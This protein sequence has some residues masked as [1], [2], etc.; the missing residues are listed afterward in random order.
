MVG[1]QRR[2]AGGAMADN[3]LWVQQRECRRG[4]VSYFAHDEHIQAGPGILGSP[5]QPP[6][7]QYRQIR[8]AG[9]Y[10]RSA[11]GADLVLIGTYFG[12]GVGFAAP[13]A[14]P[15]F[16]H[17]VEY[18]LASLPIPQ[19]IINMHE[20]PPRRPLHEW[21][22][23]AHGTRPSILRKVSYTV[24]PLTAYDA[25]FFVDAIKPSP[26]P[27]HTETLPGVD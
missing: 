27:T 11:L 25:I 15:Y 7:G 24:T 18:L 23:M 8:G 21:F 3:V 22:Q 5:G 2:D 13:D 9:R 17:D 1:S 19:F 4:R 12:H 10:L 26:P 6:A 20:L 16:A 14:P